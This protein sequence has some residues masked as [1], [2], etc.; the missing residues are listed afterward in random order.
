M[1]PN[2]ALFHLDTVN[3][4]L[5]PRHAFRGYSG[6]TGQRSSDAAG[7]PRYSPW[8]FPI[9]KW[10]S[11]MGTGV[12][13]GVNFSIPFGDGDFTSLTRSSMLLFGQ[14]DGFIEN[15]LH[16]GGLSGFIGWLPEGGLQQKWLC[17]NSLYFC[18]GFG[19]FGDLQGGL[20]RGLGRDGR[21]SVNPRLLFSPRSFPAPAFGH[22]AGFFHVDLVRALDVFLRQD[23]DRGCVHFRETARQVIKLPLLP[24]DEMQGARA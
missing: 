13:Q 1:H 6:G 11:Q 5:L 2:L 9:P 16:K 22:L 19:F 18:G 8:R 3:R 15:R 21:P 12:V 7:K 24:L 20:R 17:F 10:P 14:K 4:H 23:D